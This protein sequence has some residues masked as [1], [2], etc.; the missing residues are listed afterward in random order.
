[1]ADESQ[2]DPYPKTR[3][4][5][6]CGMK[7][8]AREEICPYCG[9]KMERS[10]TQILPHSHRDLRW[11]YLRPDRQEY[12]PNVIPLH[13]TRNEVLAL[14][15]SALVPGLGQMYNGEITKGLMMIILAAVLG[16]LF[17]FFCL[18]G[19]AYLFI[20]VYAMYD[21]YD[22]ALFINRGGTKR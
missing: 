13:K 3:Y 9:N 6:H 16:V 5:P 7:I 14:V 4:C 20:W 1:V 18:M 15:L 12:T 22:T 21:A 10:Y 17:A 11:F 8:D 2:N 19:V